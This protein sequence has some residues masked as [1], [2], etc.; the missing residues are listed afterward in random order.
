MSNGVGRKRSIG[1]AVESGS[2]GTGPVGATFVLPAL[3]FTFAEEVKYIENTAMLGSTYAVNDAVMAYK[4]ANISMKVKVDEDQFPIFLR[5]K[6]TIVSTTAPGETT[7]YQHT[8]SYNNNNSGVSFSLFV[9]DPDRGNEIFRG[10]MYDAMNVSATK[11]GFVTVELTGRSKYP[12]VFTG[13]LTVTEP[14]EFVGRNFTYKL[15]TDSGSLTSFNTLEW[16]Q[17]QTF[18]LSDEADNIFL[19]NSEMTQQFTK[20]D[21][22]E[23]EITTLYSDRTIRDYFAAGTLMKT[24]GT[25]TDLGRFVTTSV[26]NTNPSIVI[27]T[28]RHAIIEWAKDGAAGDIL[29]Q[30]FKLLT[31]DKVAISDTPNKMVIVNATPSY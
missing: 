22:F 2:F 11:D 31:L 18:S 8:A 16:A 12:V 10:F 15:T 5:Q 28:P 4:Q 3:E 26:A 23:T 1:I 19:G 17:N 24:E 30:K 29:K 6:W 9:S 21:R 14:K 27:T 20:E 25:I 13:S 7:V